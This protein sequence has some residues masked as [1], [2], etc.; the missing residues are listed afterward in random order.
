VPHLH[1]A[2]SGA[3]FCRGAANAQ[4]LSR[5]SLGQAVREIHLQHLNDGRTTNSFSV[6]YVAPE[7]SV[8]EVA[9][10]SESSSTSQ[11]VCSALPCRCTTSTK[12]IAKSGKLVGADAT[13][14]TS[15]FTRS[16]DLFFLVQVQG[17][18][19]DRAA[20]LARCSTGKFTI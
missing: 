8:V 3:V 6:D 11:L 2:A 12:C 4:Q 13:L 17:C 1:I 16:T 14:A 9:A 20:R 18:H 15:A 5:E 19:C 7:Q 10:D